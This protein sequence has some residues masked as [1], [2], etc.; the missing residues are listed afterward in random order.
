MPLILF[1]ITYRQLLS[2]IPSIV[3]ENVFSLVWVMSF[4]PYLQRFMTC[5]LAVYQGCLRKMYLKGSAS[6]KVF[7]ATIGMKIY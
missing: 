1:L 5:P 2:S 4:I 3:I 6:I 7:H